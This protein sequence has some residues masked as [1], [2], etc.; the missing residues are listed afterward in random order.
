[1]YDLIIIGAGASGL[2]AAISARRFTKN[3]LILEKNKSAGKKLKITG[4]GKCNFTNFASLEGFISAFGKNGKF[5]YSSFLSFF[6]TDIISLLDELG[7]EHIIKNDGYVFPKKGDANS[8]VEALLSKLKDIQIKY[9]SKV[10]KL[11]I[12]EA[13]VIGVEANNNKIY[14]KNVIVATGG[15]SYPQTGST[16]DGYT[17]ASLTKHKVINPIPS[18][19]ALECQGF[20][21]LQALSLKNIGF[22]IFVDN[23]K[24][25]TGQSDIIFTH[26]GVSG[27]FIINN[28]KLCVIGIL[29]NKNIK[30]VL[31]L[32]IDLTLKE[33]DEKIIDLINTHPNMLF[34]NILNLIL[35]HRLSVHIIENLKINKNILSKE[36]RSKER[37]SIVKQIKEFEIKITN[38]RPIDE[39][40]IT[41]GGVSLKDINPKT[42]ESKIVKN[43]YFI[44]EV[45]DLDAIC[46]GFN[47]QAAFS[48][49]W[50]AG[51]SCFVLKSN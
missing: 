26:F 32:L 18:L 41:A 5:L 31:D 47:L 16:G 7:I 8:L 12:K 35:A 13:N 22:S 45:L 38:F 25:K 37:L 3:I 29:E 10:E 11:I 39:A 43:L 21:D 15:L 42:M 44:G 9:N 23:K 51:E 28:S 6:S 48:T 27:P 24:F 30:I 19:I 36:L 4:G 34:I 20:K 46:G 17:F 50:L 40:M 14:S 2:L 49:G 33:L 1:M